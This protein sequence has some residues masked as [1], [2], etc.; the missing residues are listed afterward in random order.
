M[1]GNWFKASGK[2][3]NKNYNKRK[4]GLARVSLG[5][6]PVET[7]LEHTRFTVLDFETT[8]L[9]IRKDV[10]I[11]IGAISIYH[12]KIE[13]G[14]QFEYIIYQPQVKPGEATLVHGVSPEEI[15]QGKDL[16]DAL[17]EFYEYAENTVLIAFHA[18]FDKAIL[19]RA[20]KAKFN[21][22][23]KHHFLDAYD[24]GLAFFPEQGKR[25]KG[26][27][28]WAKSFG[29]D[30]EIDRHHASADALMTA[31]LMLIFL[32]KA[33]SQGIHTLGQ[34][35]RKMEQSLRLSSVQH[36]L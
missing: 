2:R 6:V 27:D 19:D 16:T 14:N 26:L 22:Q 8:G 36:S 31:E 7:R 30:V 25:L 21:C 29:L 11:S 17:I 35:L 3:E 5:P 34:F 33:Q 28:N 4:N 20:T 18:P 32:A 13:L 1:I 12:N 10:P 23:A 15:E 24:V 9:N